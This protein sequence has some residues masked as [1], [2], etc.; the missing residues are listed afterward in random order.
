MTVTPDNLRAKSTF[1]RPAQPEERRVDAAFERLFEE[2]YGRVY[3]VMFRL[4]GDRAEAEDLTLEAFWRLYRQP[5]RTAHNVGGWLYRVATRLGL[6][7]VRALQRRRRYEQ[8]AGRLE[9]PGS[10]SPN[11]EEVAVA[12]EQQARVRRALGQL[13]ERQAQ[14]LVLRHS[15]L[16]YREVAEAVGVA[17]GSVGTLLARAE[18]EFEKVYRAN[19]PME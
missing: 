5:P 11:P 8:E 1:D 4:L 10:A 7:A 9:T 6:N 12:G 2:H 14:L 19:G 13:S 15:G 18:R 16:S 17:P 3:A